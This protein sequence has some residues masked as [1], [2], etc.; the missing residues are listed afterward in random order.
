MLTGHVRGGVQH[1]AGQ[2][3]V[4]V[5]AHLRL[6]L[7]VQVPHLRAHAWQVKGARFAVHFHTMGAR[8]SARKQ[9]LPVEAWPALSGTHAGSSL[10][11]GGSITG[12]WL[13]RAWTAK[14]EPG[15]ANALL[16]LSQVV[17]PLHYYTDYEINDKT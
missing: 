8:S 16:T 17:T 14:P 7:L 11:H 3:Q 10:P 9:S 5:A 13:T 12:S 4:V 2:H 15:L 6:R 1:V